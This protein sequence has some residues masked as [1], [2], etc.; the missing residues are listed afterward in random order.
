MTKVPFALGPA[1]ALMAA[2]L[3]AQTAP[4]LEQLLG[5]P[6]STATQYENVL[7][8][9]AAKYEQAL[10]SVPASITVVTAEEIE[11]YGWTT[12]DQVLQSVPGFYLTNDRNYVYLG[13]RGIGRP[14]DYNTRILVLLNGHDLNEPVLGAAPGGSDLAVD[15]KTVERIEIV[16]GPGSALYGSHAM[17]AVVNIIT[18][19]ADDMNGIS[20]S[21]RAG[22]RGD[23][24]A[25]VRFGRTFGDGLQTTASAMWQESSGANLFYPEYDAV[26]HGRDYENLYGFAFG[27]RKGNFSLTASRRSRTKGIPTGSYESLFDVDSS[28]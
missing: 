28:T 20:A 9:A 21:A 10:G 12:L 3:L 5:T 23:R 11:R 13:V 16:R 18:Q 4:P 1:I 7:S 27:L 2:Q 8:T 17:H 14:T 15:M 19:S 6:V 24:A 26:A 22:S 25:S